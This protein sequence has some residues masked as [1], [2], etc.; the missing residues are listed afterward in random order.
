MNGVDSIENMTRCMSNHYSGIGIFILIQI[1]GV[2]GIAPTT[3]G[4]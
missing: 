3:N 2:L 4:Y 1:F